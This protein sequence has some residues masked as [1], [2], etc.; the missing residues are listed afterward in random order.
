MDAALL[1]HQKPFAR[2]VYLRSLQRLAYGP[3]DPPQPMEHIEENRE[4]AREWFESMGVK[5]EQV[6]SA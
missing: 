4:K 3:P 6:E 5:I 2:R 1:P